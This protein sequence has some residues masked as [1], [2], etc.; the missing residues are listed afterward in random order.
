MT[1]TRKVKAIPAPKQSGVV[2]KTKEWADMTVKMDKGQLV[3][4]RLPD[5]LNG[6]VKHPIN[7]FMAAM[8]RKYRR[9]FQI[10][11]RGGVIYA[12]PKEK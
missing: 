1:K 10:Y 7:A 11:A 5:H 2:R 9:T 8:K 3:E 12:I 6:S 4:V